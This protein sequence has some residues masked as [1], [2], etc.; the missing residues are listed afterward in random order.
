M[1][2][3]WIGNGQK[4]IVLLYSEGR[5][6][7]YF[8]IWEGTLRREALENIRIRRI[9][10]GCKLFRPSDLRFGEKIKISTINL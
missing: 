10:F 7:K 9:V 3:L 6:R 5:N 2:A 4:Q 1:G 8:R